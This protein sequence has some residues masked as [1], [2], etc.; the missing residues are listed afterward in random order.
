VAL[1]LSVCLPGVAARANG[2]IIRCS[3][4]GL[5]SERWKGVVGKDWPARVRAR[6]CLAFGQD[7]LELGV[8]FQQALLGGIPVDAGIG[9]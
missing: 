8:H 7:I 2:G 6:V 9:D 5:W 1:C 4:E 3:G